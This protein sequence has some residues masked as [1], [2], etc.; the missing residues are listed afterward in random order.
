MP[1]YQYCCTGKN[2]PDK[3]VIILQSIEEVPNHTFYIKPIY[4][5]ASNKP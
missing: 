4:F 3:K 1:V 2:Q 5:S